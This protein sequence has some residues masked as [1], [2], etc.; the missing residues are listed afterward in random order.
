[1]LHINNMIV[2]LSKTCL[3]Y[4]YIVDFCVHCKYTLSLI[5][6]YIV[7]FVSSTIKIVR[8]H[9]LCFVERFN[10]YQRLFSIV[11]FQPLQS[12]S[13]TGKLYVFPII[14]L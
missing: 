8:L 1:M 7:L 13:G 9:M 10:K 14:R 6:I 2:M 4:Y 3:S 5:N 12:E 11:W